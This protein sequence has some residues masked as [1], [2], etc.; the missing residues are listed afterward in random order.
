MHKEITLYLDDILE[1]INRIQTYTKG[2]TCHEFKNNDLITDAVIKK[3]ASNKRSP[4]LEVLI[5]QLKKV[6]T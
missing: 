1:A 5:R 2:M 3:P 4:F 6:K